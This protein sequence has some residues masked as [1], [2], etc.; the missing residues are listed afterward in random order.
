MKINGKGISGMVS[1]KSVW[2][3]LKFQGKYGSARYKHNCKF[4][5]DLFDT[6]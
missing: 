3:L 1:H 4:P 2:L 6:E 5:C